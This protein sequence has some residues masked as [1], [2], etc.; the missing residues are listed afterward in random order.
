MIAFYHI[1]PSLT[2]IQLQDFQVAVENMVT[3]YGQMKGVLFTIDLHQPFAID[4]GLL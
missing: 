1:I 4:T 2:P 3:N